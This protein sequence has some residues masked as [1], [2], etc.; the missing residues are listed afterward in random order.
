MSE[1]LTR[2]DTF[3]RHVHSAAFD[4]ECAAAAAVYSRWIGNGPPSD[5]S[6]V[7]YSSERSN[8]WETDSSSGVPSVDSSPYDVSKL[9]AHLY[10]LGIRGPRRW[11]PKLIFRTSKDI[12]P[13]PSGPEPYCRPMRLLP[14]Y[15]HHKLGKDNLWATIRSKVVELLDQQNIQ[16]SSVDLVRFS[17]VEENKDDKDD[18]DDGDED[19]EDNKVDEDIKDV[20][21]KIAPY[22]TV[23][24]T[25][26]TIWVG[27]LP[28]TLTGE[29]AFH[30]SNDILDLLKEHDIFDIDVAYR[31]S[32]ARGFS[33][34]ELFAPVSDLD[35]LKAVID[36]VTTALGLPIAGLKTLKSQGT[37]GFY[38]RAGKVL[39]AVMARHVL[40]PEDEGN[41]PYS[42]VAGPQK[43][44]VLMGTKAFTN[45]LISIQGHIGLLNNMITVLE[46]RA[47]VLTAR[48]QGSGP[49][50]EQAARE[51]VE[52]QHEL[53]ETPTAIKELKKF[54]VKV[55]KQWTNPRD[56]VIGHVVW[57][58]PV[59]VSAT[60]GY[61]KDVCVIKLD[62]KKFLQ[63]FR[64]NVLDLGPEIDA[65]KF[66][67]LMYPRIGAPS[68]FDYPD[69]R[70]LELR[71]I[72]SA[73]EMCIPDN[74]D[75]EGAP[76]RYVIKRSLTTLT[77]IG[78]LNG[79]ES[80]VRRYFVLG[81]RDSVEAAIYSYDNDSG[82]FSRGGDSGSIIVDALGK[83]VALLTGGT[84]L[85]YSSDITFGSPMYWLW[86]I[87]EAQFPG[88]NL[89]FEDDDN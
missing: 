44:V 82:P 35:P 43:K 42:Y 51:L 69:E 22:G 46:K 89:Y 75:R 58:P 21:I 15:E 29:K 4:K 16:H 24:T 53:S 61:T 50:A 84:G 64:G 85:S 73:E 20:D 60:H 38:F 87:I 7:D 27:V 30:S 57:A 2:D 55:K 48:S 76:M 13:V 77:T 59:G 54:F 72:L 11:G 12:F 1:P 83:F 33:G 36:P 41:F 19:S 56:R 26:V 65:S 3:E 31:E 79:F 39:Y 8:L 62:E 14:V 18:N 71:G 52:T 5:D 80:H 9:E 86:E 6:D 49:N 47:A 68:D 70:L 32:V 37:M 66:V 45:F 78:C 17:W 67:G 10:Y 23:V 88:A 28:D 25:P 63:N 34:L 74:K 81:S 40:F